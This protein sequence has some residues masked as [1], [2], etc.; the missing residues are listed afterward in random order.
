MEKPLKTP[1]NII[2]GNPKLLGARIPLFGVKTPIIGKFA[3]VPQHGINTM[4][5]YACQCF[6]YQ[7]FVSRHGVFAM[8]RPAIRL[9]PETFVNYDFHIESH[10]NSTL[11]TQGSFPNIQATLGHENPSQNSPK[12]PPKLLFI[13]T[14]AYIINPRIPNWNLTM[15]PVKPQKTYPLG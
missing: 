6:A 2:L 10:P 12:H 15:K 4:S 11:N 3:R 13:H 5:Q 7:S 1:K 8:S 14:M 9:F